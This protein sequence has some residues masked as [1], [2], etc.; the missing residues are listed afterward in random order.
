MTFEHCKYVNRKTGIH[1]YI[2]EKLGLTVQT[3]F[4]R[5]DFYYTF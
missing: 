2:D 3:A 5:A 4:P 1:Y